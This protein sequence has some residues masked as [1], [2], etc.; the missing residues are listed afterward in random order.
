MSS[1]WKLSAH[2][3]FFQKLYRLIIAFTHVNP[4]I[5]KVSNSSCTTVR[6]VHNYCRYF[7]SIL[8]APL[9]FNFDN[10]ECLKCNFINLLANKGSKEKKKEEG[11]KILVSSMSCFA[12]EHLQISFRAHLN[13]PPQNLSITKTCKL[14]QIMIM[15]SNQRQKFQL[16]SLSFGSSVVFDKTFEIKQYFQIA[17]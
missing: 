3:I 17:C 12:I 7:T 5:P 8:S 14:S 16:F 6:Q 15:Q 13:I 2:K 11:L 10:L 9:L 1:P 4:T